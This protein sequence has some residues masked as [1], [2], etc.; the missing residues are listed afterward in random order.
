M[1]I[2]TRLGRLFSADFNAVLDSIEEPDIQLKQA[3]RDM[4]FE[5]QQEQQQLASMQHECEQMN[6]LKQQIGD[7]ITALDDELD[8][9]FSAAEDD[10][11]RDLIRR[12]LRATARLET[13]DKKSLD[14][15]KA[16]LSLTARI[17][18]HRNQLEDMQQKLELLIDSNL[19][20]TIETADF[21]SQADIRKEE[22]DIAFLREKQSRVSS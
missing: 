22:I 5:L 21:C 12:K 7:R 18:E 3:V 9:C 8:I 1:A 16:C 2:I 6:G 4:Q 19:N 10:L 17:E 11:A 13:I 14:L 15:Q 20:Q